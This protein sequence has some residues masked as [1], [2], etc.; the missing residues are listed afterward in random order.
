VTFWP[1]VFAA[2]AGSPLS[3]VLLIFSVVGTLLGLL[4]LLG[5]GY[6]WFT[7]SKGKALKDLWEE[8]AKAEKARGDRLEKSNDELTQR[9]VAVEAAN[10]VLSDQVSGRSAVEALRAD[11]D[12]WRHELVT[13]HGETNSLLTSWLRHLIEKDTG[14]GLPGA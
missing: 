10:K 12:V 4:G 7:Y 11:L 14:G 6:A 13:Q 3:T 8:E 9:V 2:S 1:R 5:G